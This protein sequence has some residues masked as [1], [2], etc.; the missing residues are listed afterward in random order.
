MVRN[1]LEG[2]QSGRL[3]RIGVNFTIEQTN[4]DSIIGRTAHILF[5]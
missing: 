1:I 3:N 5:L 2:V 4:I